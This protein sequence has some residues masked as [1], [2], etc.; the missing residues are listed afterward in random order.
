MKKLT[1]N[2]LK[3]SHV[4]EFMLRNAGESPVLAITT[5]GDCSSSTLLETNVVRSE[6]Q[7]IIKLS[8]CVEY[9]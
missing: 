9:S 4:A 6:C 2:A 7:L 5:A 1:F 8:V 3:T